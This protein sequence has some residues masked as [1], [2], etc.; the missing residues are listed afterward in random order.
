[1]PPPTGQPNPRPAPRWIDI[2]PRASNIRPI[3]PVGSAHWDPAFLVD[4]QKYVPFDQAQSDHPQAIQVVEYDGDYIVFSGHHRIYALRNLHTPPHPPAPATVRVQ[5]FTAQEFANSPNA[6]A[7]FR[8]N[9]P[10]IMTLIQGAL[11][12]NATFPIV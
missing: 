12:T 8:G 7:I 11:A 5:V 4:A 1:M 2:D 10:V 9:I 3:H 6:D